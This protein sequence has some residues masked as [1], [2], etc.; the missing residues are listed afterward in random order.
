MSLCLSDE[1]VV[2]PIIHF[3]I[4]RITFCK[5]ADLLCLDIYYLDLAFHLEIA[6]TI[7]SEN[8][9]IVTQTQCSTHVKDLTESRGFSSG[10]S[11][12]LPQ[13]MLTGWVRHES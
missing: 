6:G 4:I 5:V 2:K 10:N 1:L 11:H 8:I 13:G 3:I 12:F 9:L 7:L